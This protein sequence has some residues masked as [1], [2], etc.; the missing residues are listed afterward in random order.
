MGGMHLRS[1]PDPQV[2]PGLEPVIPNQWWRIR[3]RKA[4]V[5]DKRVVHLTGFSYLA[6]QNCKLRHVSYTPCL[7]LTTIGRSSGMLRE[8]VLPYHPFGDGELVVIGSNS[9]GSADPSWVENLRAE[10]RCWMRVRRQDRAALGR[11][12]AGEERARALSTVLITRPY[13]QAYENRT[14]LLGREMPIVILSPRLNSS[15]K[16]ERP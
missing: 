3:G 5:A 1:G 10:P 13:A 6:W 4:L 2:R 8:T 7:L 15:R 9:G 14:Q 12:A 16:K 11:V